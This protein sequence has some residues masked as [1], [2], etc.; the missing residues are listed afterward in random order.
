M[1]IDYLRIKNGVAMSHIIAHQF[2]DGFNG[3]NE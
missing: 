2:I 1:V 3:I